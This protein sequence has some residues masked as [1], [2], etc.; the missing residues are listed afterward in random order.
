MVASALGLR[1]KRVLRVAKRSPVIWDHDSDHGKSSEG[2]LASVK[3]S[4]ELTQ[5]NARGS[6]ALPLARSPG[7]QLTAR[8]TRSHCTHCQWTGR[9]PPLQFTFLDF[10]DASAFGALAVNLLLN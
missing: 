9:K 8:E 1:P 10:T 5:S 2:T 6:W 7:A 4:T 3:S